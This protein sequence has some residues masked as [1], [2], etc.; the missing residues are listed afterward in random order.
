MERETELWQKRWSHS[1]FI[2]LH[3]LAI[4][5]TIQKRRNKFFFA[6]SIGA[7]HRVERTTIKEF[8]TNQ[9]KANKLGDS[10]LSLRRQRQTAQ[11]FQSVVKTSCSQ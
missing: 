8:E 1:R 10:E 4:F 6:R 3:V 2:L 11:Y 5:L 7:R 9:T